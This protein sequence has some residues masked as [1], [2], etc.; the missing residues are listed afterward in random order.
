VFSLPTGTFVGKLV[1]SE[2]DWFKARMKRIQDFD[3]DFKLRPIP[4]FVDDFKLDEKELTQIKNYESALT[5]NIHALD[6]HYIELKYL[7]AKVDRKKIE[8]I[9]FIDQSHAILNEEFLKKKR[10]KILSENFSKIQQEVEQ[11]V[12]LYK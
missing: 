1:E 10:Q 3:P 4:V 7:S 11:I 2:K 12:N 8:I 6:E 5:K 9:D